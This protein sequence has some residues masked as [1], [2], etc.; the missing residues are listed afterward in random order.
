MAT[1]TF[2]DKVLTAI[3]LVAQTKKIMAR[4]FMKIKPWITNGLI[5][6]IKHY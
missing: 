4:Q 6:S 3:G 1:K 5:I 2:V